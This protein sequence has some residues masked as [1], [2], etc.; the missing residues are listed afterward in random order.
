MHLRVLHQSPYKYVLTCYVAIDTYA[1]PAM[2]TM[3]SVKAESDESQGKSLRLVAYENFTQQILNANIRPGQFVSQRELMV[4][5][6]MPLGAIREMV[7]RLEAEGLI[8]TVPNRGLQV[9]HVDLRLIR[10]AFQLRLM[11]ER[12]AVAN[13]TR[14]ASDADLDK[15]ERAHKDIVRRA[16]AKK[17]D[18]RLLNDAQTVDWGLHDM[19]IDAMGNEIVSQIYR[20][21]SLRIRLIR[22]EHVVLK[23]DVVVPTMTEH[24]ELIAAI[25]ERDVDKAVDLL[26]THIENARQR[27]MGNFG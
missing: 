22:L 25:K 12:E 14:T 2:N 16:L 7:P 24:L 6:D 11:L 19:M 10:N 1:R 20:V 26:N 17:I 3:G 23:P 9:C 13:F 27:S 15:I 4:L 18:D 8:K 5:T 21:N